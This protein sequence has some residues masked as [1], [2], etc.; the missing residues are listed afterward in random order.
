LGERGEPELG[1]A[2]FA[3]GDEAVGVSKSRHGTSYIELTKYFKLEDFGSNL[4]FAN[5]E[6]FRANLR[7][8]FGLSQ[9]GGTYAP[10]PVQL[11]MEK[12]FSQ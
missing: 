9:G 10:V 1:T 7:R 11:E 8:N 6:V 3:G 2:R 12:A 5:R 4:G